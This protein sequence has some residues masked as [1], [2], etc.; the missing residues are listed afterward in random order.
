MATGPLWAQATLCF[1]SCSRAWRIRQ[2]LLWQGVCLSHAQLCHCADVQLLPCSVCVLPFLPVVS[3]KHDHVQV[4]A[5]NPPCSNLATRVTALWASVRPFIHLGSSL[6]AMT[7]LQPLISASRMLLHISWLVLVRVADVFGIAR[8]CAI[9]ALQDTSSNKGAYGT[10]SIEHEVLISLHVSHACASCPYVGKAYGFEVASAARPV[11]SSPHCVADSPPSS[12]TA[13][14]CEPNAVLLVLEPYVADLAA[15]LREHERHADSSDTEFP[16]H[17]CLEAA[18][19]SAA[20]HKC[21]YGDVSSAAGMVLASPVLAAR[22]AAGAL[23]NA[24]YQ[25]PLGDNSAG[26]RRQVSSLWE[27][28]ASIR[29]CGLQLS[30]AEVLRLALELA[31]AI[32]AIHD[33]AHVRPHSGFLVKR[34]PVDMPRS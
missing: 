4:M 8:P 19:R 16:C 6:I 9:K 32:S 23:L 7:P 33:K 10:R 12:A 34:A 25:L 20:M 5:V 30:V 3:C 22:M 15:R 14:H 13:D 1:R 26:C 17:K 11:P 2:S 27:Y 29:K 31:E 28:A 24:C 21:G 18:G